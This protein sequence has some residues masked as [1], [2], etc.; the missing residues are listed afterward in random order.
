MRYAG[1]ELYKPHHDYEPACGKAWETGNRHRT[2]LIYLNA[3]SGG[4]T[5][6]PR[7]SLEVPTT[8]HA[9]LVFDDA[10]PSG[11]VDERTLHEGLPPEPGHVKYAINAWVRSK[12]QRLPAAWRAQQ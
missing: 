4:G 6:F 8:A 10:L 12:D 1:G 5:G 3:V 7:L 9:A 11:E 2:F